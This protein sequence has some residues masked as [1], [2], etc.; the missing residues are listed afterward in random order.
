MRSDGMCYWH[1]AE[2]ILRTRGDDR[3]LVDTVIA[4]GRVEASLPSV[5]R[6]LDVTPVPT[7]QECV[8]LTHRGTHVIATLRVGSGR[9]AVVMIDVNESAVVY[10][11]PYQGRNRSM[12]TREFAKLFVIGTTIK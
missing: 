11:E 3:R 12:P 2:A 4:S 10:Y 1:C 5:G 9:H 7:F 6:Y 8:G